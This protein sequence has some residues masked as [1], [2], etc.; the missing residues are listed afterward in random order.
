MT[1]VDVSVADLLIGIGTGIG[2][3]S[4]RGI[5]IGYGT[6]MAVGDTSPAGGHPA[7]PNP[8]GIDAAAANDG[9]LT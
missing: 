2:S 7:A 8:S 3:G 5:G 6:N 4:G 1:S 9:G